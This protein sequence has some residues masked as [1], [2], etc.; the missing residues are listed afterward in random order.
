MVCI[1]HTPCLP[2]P[3]VASVST[4][5]WTQAFEPESLFFF[6]VSS[7]FWSLCLLPGKIVLQKLSCVWQV[8]H[9]YYG[10][11]DWGPGDFRVVR[12]NKTYSWLASPVWSYEGGFGLCC[13]RQID[14][15]QCSFRSIYKCYLMMLMKAV[16][17]NISLNLELRNPTDYLS[18]CHCICYPGEGLIAASLPSPCWA[19]APEEERRG[20]LR[21]PRCQ[22]I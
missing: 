4:R 16:E 21:C 11:D 13:G 1:W 7:F 3:L 15:T 12:Q 17:T 8:K 20:W 5:L 2:C 19:G 18:F 6:L 22:A 10:G 9:R 14:G